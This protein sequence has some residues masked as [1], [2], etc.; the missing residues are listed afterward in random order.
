MIHALPGRSPTRT[1]LNRLRQDRVA[2]V[3]AGVVA[4][5]RRQP[6]RRTV[7]LVLMAALG[8]AGCG[9][10]GQNRDLGSAPSIGTQISALDPDAT[11][12]APEVPGARRGGTVTVYAETTPDTLDPT[13]IYNV[14]AEE[15]SKLLFR[16]PTQMT[17]R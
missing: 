12:P 5:M 9:H 3:C 2:V 4:A 8:P 6:V 17:M 7:A 13:D 14:D 1:A 15:I 10:R 11:G 16:T